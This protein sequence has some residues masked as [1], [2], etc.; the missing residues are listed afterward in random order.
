[1]TVRNFLIWFLRHWGQP[2]RINL[3]VI[4]ARAWIDALHRNRV[5][6]HV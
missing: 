4:I 1:M 5:E 3:T 2:S 6:M